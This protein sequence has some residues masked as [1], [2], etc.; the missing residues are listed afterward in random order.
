MPDDTKGRGGYVSYLFSE[1]FS[2]SL[3]LF[4]AI[5]K[6]SEVVGKE[7]NGT[8]MAWL[9]MCACAPSFPSVFTLCGLYNV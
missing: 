2:V 1:R 7:E 3:I 4:M 5:I 9:L 6:Y 8:A